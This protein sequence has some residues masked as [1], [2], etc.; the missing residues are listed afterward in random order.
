METLAEFIAG[1]PTLE[2]GHTY[3]GSTTDDPNYVEGLATFIVT[4]TQSGKIGVLELV[5]G[6]AI[7][8]SIADHV[9][10]LTG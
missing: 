4:D 8:V 1:L 5:G 7:N 10:A 2:K 9:F 3:V 6:A